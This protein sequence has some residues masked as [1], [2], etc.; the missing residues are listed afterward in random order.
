MKGADERYVKRGEASISIRETL[1]GARQPIPLH[2]S[3][4]FPTARPVN[5]AN[6]HFDGDIVV[7][8]PELAPAERLIAVAAGAQEYWRYPLVFAFSSRNR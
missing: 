6:L 7:N 3:P 4:H 5:R 1:Q 2:W 8:L